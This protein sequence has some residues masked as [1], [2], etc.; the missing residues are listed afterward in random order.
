[1]GADEEHR[2]K[3]HSTNPIERL[4]GEI[5]RHTKVGIFPNSQRSSVMDL[6]QGSNLLPL[7]SE[8]MR[9]PLNRP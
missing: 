9:I 4:N 8:T 3:I 5:K 7:R 1:M 6:L 2:A